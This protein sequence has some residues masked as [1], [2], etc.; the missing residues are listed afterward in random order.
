MRN[1]RRPGPG[2]KWQRGP[3]APLRGRQDVRQSRLPAMPNSDSSAENT[4]Y[5]LM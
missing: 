4:L 1:R 3:Q 2:R 5:R